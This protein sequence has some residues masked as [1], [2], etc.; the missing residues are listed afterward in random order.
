MLAR[1]FLLDAALLLQLALLGKLALELVVAAAPEG[2]LL[3]VEMHDRVDRAV[4]QVAV[5]RDQQHGMR[6]FRDIVLQ[7]QRAFEVEIVGR[8]V[9]Q[10][11]VRLRKQHGGQRHAHAPAAGEGRGRPLLRLVVEAEAG[12]D[13]RR[14]RLGR[15]RVDVGEPHVDLGDAVRVGGG[16]FLG[17]QRRALDVGLEHDL[18]QRLLGARRFLRHLADARVLRQADRAGLGLKVAGDGAEQ[19]RLAGAVAADEPGL[20]ARRQGQRGMVEEQASGDAERKVVDDQ[21][22]RAFALPDGSQ[23]ARAPARSDVAHAKALPSSVR[24]K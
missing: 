6:I 1:R 9:E 8:L 13:G 18:D 24:W 12:K 19:R 16:L 2:Q 5:V 22:G 4:E 7:P 20:R 10:Q 17:Q 14:A 23:T 21:H 15:M 11:Q 3:L